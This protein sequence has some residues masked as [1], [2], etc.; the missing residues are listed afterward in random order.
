MFNFVDPLT[1]NQ[2]S[3]KG[4]GTSTH[5]F[6]LIKEE[7]SSSIARRQTSYL[8]ASLNDVGSKSEGEEWRE[9][10]KILGL[11]IPLLARVVIGWVGR[12]GGIE[13]EIGVEDT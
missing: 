3:T 1:F 6:C 2:R 8:E 12:G 10:E 7:Y 5:V 4:L 13:L 9:V 11:K